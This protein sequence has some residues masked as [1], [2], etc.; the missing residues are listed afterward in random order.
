MVAIL[1]EREKEGRA[2]DIQSD[3]IPMIQLV[4]GQLPYRSQ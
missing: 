2:I 1:V 4:E 3:F